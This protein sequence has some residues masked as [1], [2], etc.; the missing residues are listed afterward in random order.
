MLQQHIKNNYPKSL[1]LL[2]RYEFLRTQKGKSFHHN[3]MILTINKNN[4]D[5]FKFGIVVSKKIGNAV[6]RNYY[7]RIFRVFFRTNKIIF[8]KGYN[9]AF[10]LRSQVK[11][12]N[13]RELEEI[14]ISLIY[15]S[16][17]EKIT[18]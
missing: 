11:D 9:Y 6:T 7:K 12:Y 13:F 4:T 5:S 1:R 16:K 18:D 10:I 2:K 15:K 3:G 14:F 17:N 8:C